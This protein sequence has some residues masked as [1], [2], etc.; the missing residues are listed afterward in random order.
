MAEPQEPAPADLIHRVR[1]NILS[2]E[3]EYRLEPEALTR[4]SGS[5]EVDR[6]PYGGIEGIRLEAVPSG[7]GR[8]RRCV[9][10]ARAGSRWVLPSG[11]YAGL[12][13]LEDRSER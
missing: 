7:I 6:L 3:K 5:P 4:S 12:G 8:Q 10:G 2:A 13:R 11:H 9:V 1:P